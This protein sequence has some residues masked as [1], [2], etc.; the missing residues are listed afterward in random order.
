MQKHKLILIGC[1]GMAQGHVARFESLEERLEVGAVVDI[2]PEKAQAVSDLLPILKKSLRR[3]H[4]SSIS[5]SI[6]AAGMKL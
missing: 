5:R 3:A 1:G 4:V 2:D 6:T